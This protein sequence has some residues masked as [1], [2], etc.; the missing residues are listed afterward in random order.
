MRPAIRDAD[1]LFQPRARAEQNLVPGHF[2]C[3]AAARRFLEMPAPVA[4]NR[5]SDFAMRTEFGCVEMP[6]Q[7]TDPLRFGSTDQFRV[8]RSAFRI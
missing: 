2:P 5:A 8:P 7:R 4:R 3:N 1:L 6:R